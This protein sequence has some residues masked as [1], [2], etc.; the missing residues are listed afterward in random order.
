MNYLEVIKHVLDVILQEAPRIFK[1]SIFLFGGFWA[2]GHLTVLLRAAADKS[3]LDRDLRPFL[4]SMANVVLKVLL[5]LSVAE[6]VGFKTTSF[7]TILASAAFAIG[8]ALQGSLS[9]FA[10]GVMVLIFKPYR[11][12]DKVNI[13][14]QSGT[15]NEIQIFH[16]VVVNAQK[17]TIIIPN[18]TAVNGII[19]NWTTNKILKT[20]ILIP[21]HYGT[22]FE[23]VARI[24]EREIETTE[25]IEN[26]ASAEIKFVQF[27]KGGYTVSVQVQVA[28]A[29]HDDVVADLSKNIYNALIQSKIE[30][31][32]N[33]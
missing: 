29:N 25:K 28:P 3:G 24:I 21:I 17:K 31:G 1:A 18:A 19:S 10:A 4:I 30:L 26:K 15:V 33:K 14:G 16:T 9:N 13:Q 8:L 11:V 23:T 22:N 32:F 7:M 27:E 20:D 6:M 2:I 12:G 5:L